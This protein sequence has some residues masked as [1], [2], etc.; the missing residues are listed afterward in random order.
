MSDAVRE[1]NERVYGKVL[2]LKMDGKRYRSWW[3]EVRNECSKIQGD[4]LHEKGHGCI[5]K[6]GI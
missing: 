3:Q 4:E 5:N 6:S 2:E 1:V